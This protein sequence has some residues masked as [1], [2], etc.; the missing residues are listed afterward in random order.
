MHN[1]LLP[2]LKVSEGN[3]AANTVLLKAPQSPEVS[4]LGVLEAGNGRLPSKTFL[5]SRLCE[6]SERRD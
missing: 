5:T 1:Y 4:E 3:A 2:L 6:A